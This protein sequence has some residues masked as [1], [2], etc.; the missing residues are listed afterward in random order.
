MDKDNLQDYI[1]E[2]TDQEISNENID[3]SFRSVKGGGEEHS[4]KDYSKL[5]TYSLILAIIPWVWHI[6]HVIIS[7]V[8]PLYAVLSLLNCCVGPLMI[9]MPLFAIIL[10]IIAV[11]SSNRKHAIAG[12]V[13][14]SAYYLLGIFFFILIIVFSL[15]PEVFETIY[16]DMFNGVHY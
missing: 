6:I 13:L 11:R 7:L 14:G 8:P 4:N 3:Y 9:L 12:I 5:A 15:G 1:Q 10:G 16:S 2:Q